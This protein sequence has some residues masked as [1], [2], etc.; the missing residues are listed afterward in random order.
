MVWEAYLRVKANKGAA[1]VDEISIDG[2]EEHLKDNLYKLWNRTSSGS[3]MPP[4]VRAVSIP[5]S[6]GGERTLGIPAVADLSA[7]RQA[8]LP[9]W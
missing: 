6:N 3:Y 8:V 1:G 9:G 4:P 5:K 7:A 2:F